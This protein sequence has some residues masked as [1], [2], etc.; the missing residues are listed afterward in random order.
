MPPRLSDV[1]P[2]PPPTDLILLTILSNNFPP[3]PDINEALSA[4]FINQQAVTNNIPTIPTIPILPTIPNI[5][6]LSPPISTYSNE[7]SGS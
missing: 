2:P 4:S 5:P 7:I 3:P 6:N 1:I